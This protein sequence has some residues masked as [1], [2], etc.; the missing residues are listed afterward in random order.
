MEAG[1]SGSLVAGMLTAGCTPNPRILNSAEPTPDPAQASVPAVSSFE[2]DIEAMKTADFIFIYVFRRKDGGVLD[3]EDRS[4]LNANRPTEVNR[5][6]ISDEGRAIIFGSNFR[7]PE[8][9]LKNLAERFAFE[10]LSIP[11]AAAN[12]NTS[13]SPGPTEP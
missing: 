3:A 7:L 4:F 9:N 12:A 2:S 11:G 13:G 10:D 8:E 1:L 6:R 5:T